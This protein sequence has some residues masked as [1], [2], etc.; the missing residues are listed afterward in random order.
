MAGCWF[1]NW[2]VMRNYPFQT[3]A[4]ERFPLGMLPLL[5]TV[6]FREGSVCTTKIVPSAMGFLFDQEARFLIFAA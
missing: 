1:S 2:A 6:A 4:I 5:S 3:F